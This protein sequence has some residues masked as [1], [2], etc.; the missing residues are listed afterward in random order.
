MSSIFSRISAGAALLL[1]LGGCAAS[2][3]DV[4]DEAGSEVNA[5]ARGSARLLA[6]GDSITYGWEPEWSEKQP[7]QPKNAANLQ[8]AVL[9]KGFPEMVAK[10]LGL[11]AANASCPGEASGSFRDPQA[12]D[13]G[14]RSK[15]ADG[16]KMSTPWGSKRTQLEAAIAEVK[17][18]N[19]PKV[20]TLMLGG[21]DLF[22]LQ[23]RCEDSFVGETAC[24]AAAAKLGLNGA[25]VARL[26]ENIEASLKALH[27][28]G[29]RGTVV[30]VTIY[31]MDYAG[32]GEPLVF[33]AF[34]RALRG[35]ARDV[36]AS[37]P[38]MKIVIADAFSKFED[39]SEP[40]DR[41]ACKA[42]LLISTRNGAPILDDKG[43]PTCDRHPSQAGHEAI[44]D[45]VLEA[46]KD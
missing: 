39:R 8:K 40:H 43:K 3:D 2:G 17:S 21:N 31:A 7:G 35:A 9:G 12:K 4:T 16:L 42:G 28:A 44:A 10:R 13:N 22:L 18:P 46:L 37:T 1:T 5:A 30:L 34:N 20:I 25:P 14:C 33:G 36:Q 32:L 11:A 15:R 29:Y 23:D 26:E 45:A 27:G 19:P 41:S 24:I 38:G 6:L